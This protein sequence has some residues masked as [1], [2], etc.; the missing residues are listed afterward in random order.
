MRWSSLHIPTRRDA[1]AEAD[2]ISHRLLVRG[3]FVRQLVSGHY[4]L[5]P[6][7]WRVVTKIVA[8]IDTEMERIG[9][10]QLRMPTMHPA[11][12]WQR[13]GRWDS[14]G[15]IMFRLR[16]RH[17]ADLALGVTAEEIFAT[18][19][20]ELTSYRQLPQVWYQTHTKYRDEARPKSGLLRLREFTMTDSYSF[21]LDDAGLDR[22]FQAHHEAYRRIFDRLDLP[23]IAVQ[24]SSGNMGG[25]DSV[26]FMVP[27]TAGED[28]VVRCTACDYAANVERAVAALAPVDDTDEPTDLERFATPG[29]RTI[30]DLAAF[31]GGAPAEDQIK[32]LAYVLDGQVT[33]VL[34]RGDHRLNDQKLADATGATRLRAASSEEARRALGADPGSLGAVG[35]DHLRIIADQ[36]LRGRTAMTTGANTDG[37]HLRGVDLDRDAAVGQWADLRQV[38]AGETCVECG[39]VLEVV[40]T[41]E[42]GHIFKLGRTY[43]EAFGATIV[44]EHGATVPLV[45]GSY[46][47]GIERNLATIVETHHDD[48][49]I[50]WPIY[51]APYEVVVSI[52]RLDEAST[53]AATEIYETLLDR[54]VE[55]MLDDRDL[56]PGVKFADAE[57]IG[58]PWRVTVGPKGLAGG[59]V[60]V[61]ERASS[62]T[63]EVPLADAAA[64]VTDAVTSARHT[65]R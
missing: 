65:S 24:A 4:V 33:L 12:T 6:L 30:A 32:T 37:W 17:G 46:G 50:I 25:T 14:M 7:G 18:V 58:I 64:T 20:A 49:G 5:L 44:D 55:A 15:E 31:D 47:I 38:D 29:V 11:S 27:A 42:A 9:A 26:E 53:A 45:M 13:S 48:R 21:D 8:V 56:R 40:A 59:V 41:I 61:T 39:G 3:G 63:H 2:A 22:S 28:D 34:L 10:Q 51:V 60:E 19:A 36:A 52:V 23:A 62:T 16:D 54:G 43:A 57:L 1:P 35:V